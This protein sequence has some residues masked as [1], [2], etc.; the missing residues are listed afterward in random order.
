MSELRWEW[1][2]TGGVRIA[3]TLDLDA[4]T[5][6]VIVGDRVVSRS[7]RGAKPD[8]HVATE[9]LGDEGGKVVVTFDPRVAICILSLDGE[10]VPPEKWPV[11]P[12]GSAKAPPARPL[13]LGLVALVLT[14]VAFI[15]GAAYVVRALWAPSGDASTSAPAYRADN[16]L[17]VAHFPKSLVVG[18]PVLPGVMS[19]V[20]LEDASKG[21]AVI[22]VAVPEAPRDPWVLQSKLHGEALANVPRADGTYDETQRRDD[23]C[24]GQK[25]AVVVGK[26]TNKKGEKARLWSCAFLRGEAGYLVMYALRASATPSEEAQVRGVVEA[27]ELTRLEDMSGTR[28]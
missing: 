11:R 9:R 5:E 27:T 7:A 18:K 1:G 25:G 19:G 28:P 23:T 22:I 8:G 26:V 24:L 15:G 4:A 2:L 12:R 21:D 14:A 17:F 16:G 3:A 6:C 10:E 13:P 20:V